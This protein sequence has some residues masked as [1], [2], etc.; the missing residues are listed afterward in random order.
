MKLNLLTCSLAYLAF[1]ASAGAT[2]IL[3]GANPGNRTI[4]N[5]AGANFTTAASGSIWVGTFSNE[6]GF[7][8]TANNALSVAT[9]VANITSAGGWERFGFDT[10]T[11]SQNAGLSSTVDFTITAGIARVGGQITDN[12]AGATKADFFNGKQ[13]YLWV[14]NSD[15]FTTATEMGIFEATAAT[16]P[17]LFPSNAGGLG[18]SVTLSTTTGGST[19]AAVNGVGSIS[20]TQL[21]T[22]AF[23]VIPEPSRIVFLFLG[24]MGLIIRRRR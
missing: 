15:D 5:E 23:G 4:A 1:S 16:V 19:L 20:G 10:A 2:T 17:W 13:V 3:F 9:N 22:E 6:A 12:V 14:F 7:A 21:R 18:D 8:A 11:E 24:M